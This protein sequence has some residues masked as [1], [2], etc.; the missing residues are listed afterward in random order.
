MRD[1]RHYWRRCAIRVRELLWLDKKKH[2]DKETL[3]LHLG[4]LLKG[5]C[6][7][8]GGDQVSCGSSNANRASKRLRRPLHGWNSYSATR[9]QL[10]AETLAAPLPHIIDP[11]QH[12]VMEIDQTKSVQ[13]WFPIYGRAEACNQKSGHTY[14]QYSV[15][16]KPPWSWK[17]SRMG[18]FKK[19][20]ASRERALAV[21]S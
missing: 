9:H 13:G 16:W 8:N 17:A 7:T 5:L 14:Q 11:F 19:M 6:R 20:W 3:N 2:Y 18:Y 4:K 10:E 1:E 12:F 21:K 15:R